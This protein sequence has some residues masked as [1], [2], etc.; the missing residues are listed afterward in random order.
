MPF[1]N[2]EL[3]K[4][5][6]TRTKLRNI[7]LQ[8][9]SVKNR[10]HYTKQTHFCVTL[11][12]KINKR[13]YENLNGKSFSN[14]KLFWK[15]MK[16]LLSDKVASKDKIHFVENN[17]LFKTDLKTAKVLNNFFFNIVQK[18]DISRYSNNTPIVSNNNDA[19]LKAILKYR[20]YP[21]IIEI[22][23]KCKDKDS[24]NFIE[25]DQKQIECKILKLDVNKESTDIPIKF[26]KENIDIL[27]NVLCKSFHNSINL[28][29]FSEIFNHADITS[30]YKKGK[31]DT[32]QNY[33]LVSILTNL[34]KIFGKFIFKQMS[35]FFE[36]IFSKYQCRFQKGFST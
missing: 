24:F 29:T 32:K 26:V 22:Q 5:I 18:R 16:T 21:S 35:Q 7:F 20:N 34:S 6:M 31:K 9:R 25:V 2:K 12:R 3:L 17:E 33:R 15:T 27:S 28:S 11:L 23:N 36:N 1:L 19:T 30:L 13:Y 14:N 8:N 10:I 4:A